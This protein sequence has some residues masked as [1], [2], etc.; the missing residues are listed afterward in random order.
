MSQTL[1]SECENAEPASSSSKVPPAQGGA[2][3]IRGGPPV[4]LRAMGA[5]CHVREF[6]QNQT[7]GVIALTDV[8]STDD[9]SLVHHLV[10]NAS[11]GSDCAVGIAR[12]PSGDCHGDRYL[13]AAKGQV[14]IA[15]QAGGR[16]LV[17]VP[18]SHRAYGA[19]VSEL[20]HLAYEAD[21]V[22]VLFG[23]RGS[24]YHAHIATE[25]GALGT[26][27]GAF[28]TARFGTYPLACE[29][30]FAAMALEYLLPDL[31]PR[32]W[33]ASRTAYFSRGFADRLH[34]FAIGVENFCE[35]TN[36]AGDARRINPVCLQEHL[37]ALAT[38]L[39]GERPI[40]FRRALATSSGRHVDRL[41]DRLFGPEGT[42]EMFGN[43]V[44][45]VRSQDLANAP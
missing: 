6:L 1:S 43:A 14:K 16:P 28:Q 19:W 36:A 8:K 23:G 22:F 21:A 4:I 18:N 2:V 7:V 39:Y 26:F 38:C 45:E 25:M 35:M 9:L 3:A 30:Q 5:A 31:Q 42:L 20:H 11:P 10:T 27:D 40:N 32:E 15:H 24:A 34:Q 41:L 33:F 29:V 44:P 37:A 12:C 17:F 13:R